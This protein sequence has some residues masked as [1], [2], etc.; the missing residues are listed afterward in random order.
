MTDLVFDGEETLD[1]LRALAD[2]LQNLGAAHQEIIIVGGSYLAIKNLRQATRDVDS[3][4]RVEFATKRAIAEIGQSRGYEADW[5]N[6]AAASFYPIGLTVDHCT[7]LLEHPS[8]T[9]LGPS[10]DWI[11]LMKLDAARAIDL[12]DLQKLW[13]H[14]GFLNAFEVVER[15][16][17]AYPMSPTDP[18]LITYVEEIIQAAK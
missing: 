11:F 12:P 18:Y 5:L 1:A 4:T 7:V 14:T 10:A 3:V 8:L 2:L 15:F 17:E 13:A 6:D 9:V 16:K